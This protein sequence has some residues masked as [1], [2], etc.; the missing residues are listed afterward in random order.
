MCHHA[1]IIFIFLVE[2][3]FRHVGHASLELLTSG[4]PPTLASQSAGMTGMSH[5]GRPTVFFKSYRVSST[6]FYQHRS[7]SSAV[8][9]FSSCNASVKTLEDRQ[10]PTDQMPRNPNPQQRPQMSAVSTPPSAAMAIAWALIA[11]LYFYLKLK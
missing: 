8:L 6:T 1:Q 2:T 7:L 10:G 11:L 3:Q 4:D 9:S 5:C